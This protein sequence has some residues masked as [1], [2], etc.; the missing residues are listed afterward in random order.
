MLQERTNKWVPWVAREMSVGPGLGQQGGAVV[1]GSTYIAQG[2]QCPISDYKEEGGTCACQPLGTHY[3][4]GTKA[5]AKFILHLSRNSQTR[6]HVI[7]CQH[8]WE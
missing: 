2:W 8:H 6:K 4:A 1:G 7:K 3:I 5:G